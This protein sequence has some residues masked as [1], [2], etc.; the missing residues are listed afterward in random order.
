MSREC[1]ILF[2]EDESE[3]RDLV[4]E[5][6]V[7]H[8]FKVLPAVNGYQAIQIL[9]DHHVDLLLS[10]VVLPGISGFELARQA[11]VIRPDLRV[12]YT[13]GYP[14]HAD[15]VGRVRHGKLLQK[16]LRMPDLIAEIDNAITE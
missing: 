6:L 10:D 1:T 4:I 14:H 5:T 8:G 7:E 2:V 15:G 3:M 11:K 12:L 9:V 16:P 13:S